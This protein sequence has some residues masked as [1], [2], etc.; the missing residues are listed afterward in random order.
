MK[1]TIII[2]LI[3]AYISCSTKTKKIGIQPYGN[4]DITVI[5]AMTEILK[6]SYQTEVYILDKKELP[7]QAFVNIKSPRYRADSLLIDLL[8]TRPDSIDYII[9]ITS[10]DISTTKRNAKGEIK[11]PESKYSDWGIF[12]LGYKPGKSCIV[13]TF[14]LKNVETSLFKS[15]LQKVSVHEI[16]HN[17]GLDHC[18]TDKCVMQ[19][20]VESIN[21]VDLANFELCQN[22]ISKI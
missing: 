13:S 3:F 17:M 5:D 11:K 16:G 7:Q 10:K 22:C 9:G 1:K 18:K 12:G 4:I 21:T 20:A 8:Q 2:I 14:R 15:R 6:T 19:D